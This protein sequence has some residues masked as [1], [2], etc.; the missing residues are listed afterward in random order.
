MNSL[1]ALEAAYTLIEDPARWTTGANARDR[2]G[3]STFSPLDPSAVCWCASGALIRVCAGYSVPDA[4][5]HFLEMAARVELRQTVSFSG[6]A[7]VTVNDQGSHA[8]TL[9]MLG[10]AAHLARQEGMV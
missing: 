1:A 3:M 2:Y 5:M 8:A 9:R 4:A 10:G 7:A 6:N